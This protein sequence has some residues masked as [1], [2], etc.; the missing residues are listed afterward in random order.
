MDVIR[1]TDFHTVMHNNPI[2]MVNCGHSVQL[3]PKDNE[4]AYGRHFH[5]TCE[6]LMLITGDACYNIDGNNY[7][8]KPYDVLL[9]PPSTYHFLIPLSNEPYESY[10][11][12]IKV[13]FVGKERLQKLFSPPYIINILNDSMLRRM[14]SMLDYYFENYSRTDFKEASEHLLG[15]I[16]IC[17]SYKPK[18]EIDSVFAAGN[19]PLISRITAF[20]SENLD[21]DLNADMIAKHLNFSRSYVQNQFSE[22]MGIGLKQYINQKKIYAA[23]AD[24]QNGLSPNEAA[25]KY[26]FQD[27]SGFFRQYKKILGF[28][29]KDGKDGGGP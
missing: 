25:R 1:Y 20:V 11:I 3:M 17:L 16:L 21:Q 18:E 13:P 4:H 29:P 7:A 8:L 27:Y 22:V 2:D 26:C 14:F 24:I 9:I 12:N 15:E 5:E 10:V 6:L 19:N 28:S 23:H